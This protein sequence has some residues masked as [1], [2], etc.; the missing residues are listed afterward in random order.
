M[1]SPFV[2]RSSSYLALT[3]FSLENIG[4]IVDL[5]KKTEHFVSNIS[6][7]TLC[8]ILDCVILRVSGWFNPRI[9]DY[10]NGYGFF[11]G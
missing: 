3:L 11:F 1:P 7:N 2:S 5:Q 6:S 10:V 4:H 8:A 9:C